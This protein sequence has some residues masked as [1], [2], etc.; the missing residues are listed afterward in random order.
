MSSTSAAWG[1]FNSCSS[2]LPPQQI[3]LNVKMG[4]EEGWGKKEERKGMFRSLLN[5][6]M[7]GRFFQEEGR[8]YFLTSQKIREMEDSNKM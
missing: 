3:D 6:L 8:R 1:G 5:F 2:P 7:V 4:G